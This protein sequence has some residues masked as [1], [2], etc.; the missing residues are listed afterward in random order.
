MGLGIDAAN[1]FVNHRLM[2]AAADLAAL[3]GA[4]SLPA[5]A[6]TASSRARSVA[7]A[8]GYAS[9]VTVTTPY[10]ANANLI[11]VDIHHQVR[12]FFMPILGINTVDV[13]VRAVA[14]ATTATQASY[15]IFAGAVTCGGDS[16]KVL[17]W[18][19]SKVAVVGARSEER[20]V[21]KECSLRRRLCR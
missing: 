8:N 9:G 3:A 5:D 6:L 4:R 19:G 10:A 16:S 18:S 1:I 7:A 21:G 11:E 12:P 17:E 2:Q 13:G 14:R 20:R 15:A